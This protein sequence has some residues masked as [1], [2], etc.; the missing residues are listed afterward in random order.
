[1]NL[2]LR[3][4]LCAIM[5]VVVAPVTAFAHVLVTDTSGST[6]AIIHIVPDDDPV[7][8]EQSSIFIDVQ[9]G[10]QLTNPEFTISGQG[11]QSKIE[12]SQSG[13]MLQANYTFPT[14]GVYR[15]T[16]VSDSKTFIYDHHVS[17]GT[18]SD[19]P[20]KRFIWAEIALIASVIALIALILIAINRR[21]VI[22]AA[23][24]MK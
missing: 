22:L 11:A 20:T 10:Q 2:M 15:L 3:S 16:L 6:G 21:K 14:Q 13:N 24:V 19:Q 12:L 23:S 4:F 7:A 9:G 17:R 1:M 5:I 18:A 8:G